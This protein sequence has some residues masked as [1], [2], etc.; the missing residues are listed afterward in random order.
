MGGTYF[1]GRSGVQDR[2]YLE[3]ESPLIWHA[4]CLIIFDDVHNGLALIENS[5]N[6]SFS[7]SDSSVIP[8][9]VYVKLL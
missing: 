1:G 4:N 2:L 8:W 6:L 9:L 7:L 5:W 3:C